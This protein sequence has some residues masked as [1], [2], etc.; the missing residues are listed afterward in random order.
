MRGAPVLACLPKALAL[1]QLHSQSPFL[2]SAT[3]LSLPRSQGLSATPGVGTI[4][5]TAT[6]ALLNQQVSVRGACVLMCLSNALTLS[7]LLSR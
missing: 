4:F 5:P 1:S 3:R 6:E 7:Q 2:R